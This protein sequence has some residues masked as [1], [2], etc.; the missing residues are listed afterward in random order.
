MQE[1]PVYTVRGDASGERAVTVE[2]RVQMEAAGGLPEM[3]TAVA[4]VQALAA[5]MTTAGALQV[6]ATEQN[7]QTS[8]ISIS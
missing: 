3:G 1:Y 8:D 2:L 5:A 6:T 7:I 4:V